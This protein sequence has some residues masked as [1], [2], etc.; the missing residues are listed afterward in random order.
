MS[1]FSLLQ[2][3]PAVPISR[4][5]LLVVVSNT[6]REGQAQ[7]ECLPIARTHSFKL[8]QILSCPRLVA[9]EMS[10]LASADCAI[11]EALGDT[12]DDN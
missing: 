6:E 4:T 9:S 8:T 12:L 7:F 1:S 10:S 11:E 3:D 2:A 5:G